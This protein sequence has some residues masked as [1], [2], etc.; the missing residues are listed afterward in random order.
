[1]KGAPESSKLELSFAEM[2]RPESGLIA[3]PDE[4]DAFGD[5][6][7]H[8]M[9][10]QRDAKLG[11]MDGHARSGGLDHE[12]FLFR[13]RLDASHESSLFELDANDAVAT[14]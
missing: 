13:A 9:G 7:V 3:R 5:G 4:H 12:R 6:N 1:M 10:R 2:A 14:S 8:V 11:A